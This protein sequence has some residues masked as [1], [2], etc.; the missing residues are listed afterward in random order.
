MVEVRDLFT[1]IPARLKFL[2]S[3]ATELKRAQELFTRLALAGPTWDSFSWRLARGAALRGGAEPDPT[4]GPVVAA[5]GGGR[6]APLRS[7]RGVRPRA[8]AGLQPALVPTARRP[9][10]VLRQRPGRQRQA[11]HAGRAPGLSGTPDQ[12]RLPAGGAV[13]GSSARRSGRQRPS[14]PKTKSVF[15]TNKP[16]S[17]PCC[18]PWDRC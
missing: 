16:C 10:V 11:H 7:D 6:P 3:P 5:S 18:A 8:G 15:G 12:P 4:P 1:N 9:H 17:W 14:R 13:S 2:K